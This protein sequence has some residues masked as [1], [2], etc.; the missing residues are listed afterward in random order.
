MSWLR[1][2]SIETFRR[3]NP[4]WA[5]DVCYR[6]GDNPVHRSDL[7]RYGE[8]DARGGV[9]FD[10]D[11]VFLKQFPEHLLD[12]D[13]G[14]TIT[15]R[16]R[17]SNIGVLLASPQST[18]YGAARTAAITRIENPKYS[19]DSYQALGVG[20][21]NLM[22][23][24]ALKMV[25]VKLDVCEDAFGRVERMYPGEK[26]LN[27]PETLICP[28][29]WDKLGTLYDGT[30]VDIP[31]ESIGIHWFGGAQ[32]SKRFEWNVEHEPDDLPECCM[33]QALMVAV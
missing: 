10:T 33:S 28:V 12:C 24:S 13:V 8:L 31:K 9:Y 32:E 23:L 17:F 3:L 18:F 27:L 15:D 11:I 6:P 30:H 25:P 4:E 21:L 19:P 20:L 5:V 1:Q 7:F 29:Q 2:Q 14:I 26:W 22:H 16:L